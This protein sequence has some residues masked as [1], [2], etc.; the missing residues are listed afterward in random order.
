MLSEQDGPPVENVYPLTEESMI[1]L[2]DII[3]FA[4]QLACQNRVVFIF[5]ETVPN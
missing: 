4:F 5:S 1:N 3:L 2:N